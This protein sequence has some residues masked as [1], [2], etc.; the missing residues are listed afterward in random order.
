MSANDA[1]P[2]VS[3]RHLSKYYVR[4]EQ[5]IP[6]LVDISL[7]VDAG[8][9]L[10]L[11]GPSGS[12]KSTL[13]NLIAGIDKPSSGNVVVAGIDIAQLGESDLAAWRAAN[14]GFIFQFYN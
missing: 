1:L 9:Y 14:I 13:L 2:L 11:M 3:V 4:G 10:A 8:D 12:G 5:L 7:D 6:V